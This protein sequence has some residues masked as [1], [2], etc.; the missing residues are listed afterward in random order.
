MGPVT[1]RGVALVP[2]LAR[3]GKD[4]NDGRNL[5]WENEYIGASPIDWAQLNS[6][7]QN[8]GSFW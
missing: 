3:K 7:S 8:P 2:V 1:G 6:P 4:P 5:E